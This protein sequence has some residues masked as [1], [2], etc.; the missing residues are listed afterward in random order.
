M[1]WGGEQTNPTLEELEAYLSFLEELLKLP[2]DKGS[3]KCVALML[4]QNWT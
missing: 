3:L 4:M 2:E 1:L